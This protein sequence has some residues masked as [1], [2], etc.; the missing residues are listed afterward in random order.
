MTSPDPAFADA[1]FEGVVVTAVRPAHRFDEPAL[2]RY[3]NGRVAGFDGPLAVRQFEGGQSNPTFV[4]ASAGR[5]YVMRKKPPGKLL[6][7]AHAVDREYRAMAAL[8]DS[9]VPV[10]RML[11]L[12]TDD[13]VIGTA[14]YV[15]EHVAGRVLTDPMLPQMTADERTR[16]HGDL[17]DVL[18][19]LHNV[20]PEAVGLAD[21]GRPGNY[22]IRQIERWSK[23]YRASQTEAIPAMEKLIEWLPANVPADASSGIVHGD[24]R[25]GNCLVHPSE[26]RIVAV[27]DWELSTLGHPLGDVAYCCMPYRGDLGSL[28]SLVG[29]GLA[30][31]GIP[32]EAEFLERYCTRTGRDGIADWDFYMVFALFRIAAI[33]QGV[34]KRG[35]DGNASSE[36]ARSFGHMCRL[37]AE[38]AWEI[39]ERER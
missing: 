37:R 38:I 9:G 16:L 27:L 24:Y 30:A 39:A 33:V 19:K 35:L 22:Y 15:M 1:A 2:E 32:S 17:I 8:A 20:R 18:A 28:G 3:L 6:P 23:Q 14:F 21:Y 5:R 11:H 13:A 31:N 12:C 4:L 26:P 29:S 7:S 10:P 25:L 36:S 34:Y